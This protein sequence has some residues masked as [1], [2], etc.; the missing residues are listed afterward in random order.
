VVA[1]LDWELATIGNPLADLAYFCLTYRLPGGADGRSGVA[2]EDLVG[3]GIPDQQALVAS[4]CRYADREQPESL[5]AFIVFSLF[6]L[7]SIV[8]GVWRRGVEG[9]AADTRATE[10]RERYREL[11]QAG[12][13]LAQR[14]PAAG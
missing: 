4:Y 11:A 10:F 14:F 2:G 1:V 7:A 6:R 9:N 12:W 8:A 13:D 3:T 5:D